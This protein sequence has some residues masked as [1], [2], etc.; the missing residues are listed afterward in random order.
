MSTISAL[1]AWFMQPVEPDLPQRMLNELSVLPTM[2][3][4]D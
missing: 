4:V 1:S 2:E 3:I